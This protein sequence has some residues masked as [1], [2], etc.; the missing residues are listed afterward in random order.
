MVHVCAVV[1][2]QYYGIIPSLYHGTNTISKGLL[3]QRTLMK[4]INCRISM[5]IIVTCSLMQHF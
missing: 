1:I 4:S 5:S 2:I 3:V